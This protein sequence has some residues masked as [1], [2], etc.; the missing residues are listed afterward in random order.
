M[1][2]LHFTAGQT[3]DYIQ[4]QQLE[5]SWPGTVQSTNRGFTAIQFVA[6]SLFNFPM[7]KGNYHDSDTEQGLPDNQKLLWHKFTLPPKPQQNLM[8]ANEPNRPHAHIQDLPS[9]ARA[10]LTDLTISHISNW[11]DNPS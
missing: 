11:Y 6:E 8:P 4:M 2:T 7:E 10:L 9:V 1:L 5:A 3:G